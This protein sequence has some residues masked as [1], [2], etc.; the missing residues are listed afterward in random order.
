MAL[1]GSDPGPITVEAT[2]ADITTKLFG[3]DRFRKDFVEVLRQVREQMGFLLIGW[4]LMPEHCHL[5]IKPEPA[6]STASSCKS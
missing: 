4:V 3:S 5:L 6:E 2:T 1:E